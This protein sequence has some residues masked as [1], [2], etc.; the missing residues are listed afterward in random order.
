MSFGFPVSIISLS[1]N[2]KAG[3]TPRAIT[4][5]DAP[6][7]TGRTD[8]RNMT[9]E[10]F[11][12]IIFGILGEDKDIAVFMR[13]LFDQILE[14]PEDVDF[15]NPL[16]D[17]SAPTLRKYVNP[18]D[19][20]HCLPAKIVK[21]M[22]DYIEPAKF[23]T[24]LL[25]KSDQT[26]EDLAKAF[27][28]YI[29]GVTS[30][31]VH[32]ECADLFKKI[33]DDII[34][35]NQQPGQLSLA[36]VMAESLPPAV[37]E[38][39]GARLL[40]ETEGF[41]PAKGC[42]NELKEIADDGSAVPTYAP[43]LIDGMRPPVFEN[44]IALCPACHARY[45]AER[46]TSTQGKMLDF[47]QKKK[48][49]L[50]VRDTARGVLPRYEIEVGVDR[51]LR[52]IQDDLIELSDADLEAL[53]LNYDPVKVRQ[54]IPG[55]TREQRILLKKVL[56]YVRENYNLVDNNLKNLNKEQVLRQRVFSAQ[57]K[58]LFIDFDE[59]TVDGEPLSQ[60]V[61]FDNL[62]RWLH[63]NTDED[64]EVCAIVVS[65]FVQSCEVFDVIP[66]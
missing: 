55:D 50:M 45:L 36:T 32:D 9:F 29:P 2:K 54:K 11:F 39:F 64:M 51:L 53:R 15:T 5:Q 16:Y 35:I 25:T 6:N 31:N 24:Y 41:C 38:Q 7:L 57:I 44:L 58:N 14:P 13:E 10:T 43:T 22:H 61:I 19:T 56:S 34:G 28:P 63:E 60:T 17:R 66:E 52:K 42:T 59:T 1:E 21:Q 37:K 47:L 49:E 4:R 8:T 65:Y 40:L 26:L 12:N 62:V 3:G 33:L 23:S 30:H 27:E 46:K 20:K 18:N 48:Q